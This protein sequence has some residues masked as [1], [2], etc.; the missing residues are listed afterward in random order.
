MFDAG[1]S[2]V[3]EYLGDVF[4]GDGFAGFE[5]EVSILWSSGSILP[6][7]Q[8]SELA[9]R[10]HFSVRRKAISLNGSR[11]PEHTNAGSL[12]VPAKRFVMQ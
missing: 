2:Q 3:A 12:R 7:P 11:Q 4:V 8:N 6:P 9:R 5:L 10:L 1:S